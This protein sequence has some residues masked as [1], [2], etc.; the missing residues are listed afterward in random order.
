M[1]E[2]NVKRIEL[3]ADTA[4]LI[5]KRVKPNFKTLGPRYGKYMKQI[6]ALTA[7]V[8]AGADR[9]QSKS[10]RRRRRSTWAANGSR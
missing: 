9:S 2:V 8:H 6:A 5:T 7:A 10:Q 4:G 1:N 3:V